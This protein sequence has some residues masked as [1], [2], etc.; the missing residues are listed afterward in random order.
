MPG[1]DDEIERLQRLRDRQLQAR[2]PSGKR[3]RYEVEYKRQN[4]ARKG[5]TLRSI[6]NT[7]SNKLKGLFIGIIIGLIAWVL[8]SIFVDA[9]WKDLAGFAL[10]MLCALVGVALGASFDW[11][12]NLRNF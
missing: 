12:D 2:D 7:F 10:A 4:A 8:V 3:S 1:S 9:T 6:F 11:R 5:L